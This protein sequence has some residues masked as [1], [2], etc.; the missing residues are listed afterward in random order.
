MDSA[1]E[2]A[3]FVYNGV[4]RNRFAVQFGLQILYCFHL[5]KI[6]TSEKII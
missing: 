3:V 5:F 2:H 4:Q 6:K 1:H